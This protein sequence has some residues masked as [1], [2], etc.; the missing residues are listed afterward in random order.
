MESI[1]IYV[2]TLRSFRI[3]LSD[4]LLSNCFL[5]AHI[6]LTGK[7]NTRTVDLPQ[8]VAVFLISRPVKNEISSPD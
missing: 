8:N 4:C 7:T 3:D 5:D 6:Q 1:A 2:N